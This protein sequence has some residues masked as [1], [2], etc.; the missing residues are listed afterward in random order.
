MEVKEDSQLVAIQFYPKPIFLSRSLSYKEPEAGERII[1]GPLTDFPTREWRIVHVLQKPLP[2][3]YLS[4]E[5][6]IFHA[7]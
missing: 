1:L 7:C 5:I 2:D 6:F 3:L 4:V